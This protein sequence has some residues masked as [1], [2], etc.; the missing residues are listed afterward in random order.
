MEVG[1]A[2]QGLKSAKMEVGEEVTPRTQEYTDGSGT[3][4]PRTQ[5]SNQDQGSTG[6]EAG[7]EVTP[8]VQEHSGDCGFSN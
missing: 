5:P 7:E 8:R 2:H 4:T 3:L 1:H 6:M